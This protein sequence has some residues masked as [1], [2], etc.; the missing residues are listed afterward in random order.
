MPSLPA[1][2]R[3][4]ELASAG[5]LGLFAGA[6]LTEGFVLVPYWRSLPADAFF[7][8]YAVNDRRLMAFF[9]PVTSAAAVV[10]LAA[11][12]AAVGAGLPGRWAASA[13]A[14]LMLGCVA[15]FFA[16]FEQANASFSAAS[17]PAG[18]LPKALARWA[19]WHHARTLVALLALALMLLAVGRA[20]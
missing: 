2:A 15:V 19:A 4:L 17:V 1:L 12:L 13:S 7:A 5:L 16:W 18:E 6:M 9:G 10:T 11:A 3:L 14:A 20:A 8:W